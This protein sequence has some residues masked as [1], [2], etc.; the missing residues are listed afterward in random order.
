M[1]L[2]II[3]FFFQIIYQSVLLITLRLKRTVNRQDYSSGKS[4]SVVICAKNEAENLRKNLPFIL[5]QDYLHYE[6]IVV[7]DGSDDGTRELEI[8]D[9]RLKIIHLTKEEK[10]GLGKKYALQKGVEQAKNEVILLTDADCRP[11]SKNWISEMV[12]RINEKHKIV[13]GVSPYNKGKNV[14]NGLIEYETSQTALQYLGW[15]LL[16]Y[17]YMSVGRNVAYDAN[18]LKKK[19]WSEKELSVASGDDDLTIQTLAT[20]QNTTVCL[21]HDGYTVSDA[22]GNWS[23][24]IKQKLRHYES[25]V[26]YTFSQRI[27]LGSYLLTKLFIYVVA[28]YFFVLL[29]SSAGCPDFFAFPVLFYLVYVSF[30]IL[31]NFIL[32]RIFNLNSKWYLAGLYDMF[33]V[34]LAVF[35]GIISFFKPEQNWK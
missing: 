5:R 35:L 30:L 24:W 7:D 33:Y 22:K 17:P 21:S 27:M 9:E 34:V 4:V 11:L 23:A 10:V 13:L 2:F 15:A 18:L 29:V 3:C 16:G 20:S 1:Y 25:G 31:F 12:E 32:D 28:A 19:I 8:K 14:L 26:F 6:V